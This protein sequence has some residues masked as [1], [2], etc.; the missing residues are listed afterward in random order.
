MSL[1]KDPSGH[2]KR[3]PPWWEVFGANVGAGY[4]APEQHY[5]PFNGTTNIAKI[6]GGI[7]GYSTQYSLVLKLATLPTTTADWPII[8]HLSYSGNVFAGNVTDYVQL[9]GG[10]ILHRHAGITL[11]GGTNYARATASQCPGA[12]VQMFGRDLTANLARVRI[13]KSSDQSLFWAPGDVATAEDS[14][15]DDIII[16]GLGNPNGTLNSSP[17]DVQLVAVLAFHSLPSDALLQAYASPTCRDAR[18]IF[19]SALKGY[20]PVSSMA[21]SSVPALIGSASMACT[22]L[23]ASNLVAY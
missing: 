17:C 8:A 6:V 3:H 18:P 7:L 2:L 21:G 16:G 14:T 9:Q 5:L 1:L 15:P 11:A 23:T 22:G 20:W 4:V 10:A 12:Q 19:G 13:V